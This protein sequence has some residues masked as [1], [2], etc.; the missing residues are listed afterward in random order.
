[1]QRNRNKHQLFFL[2]FTALLQGCAPSEE[3]L[4]GLGSVVFLVFLFMVILN[5]VVPA[6][7]EF[8]IIRQWLPYIERMIDKGFIFLVIISFILIFWGVFSILTNSERSSSDLI[9]FIG[10]LFFYLTIN[11]K[12]W[13]IEKDPTKKKNY[14]RLVGL[15]L[16]FISLI[17]YLMIGAPNLKL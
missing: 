10:I 2:F 16:S 17:I 5:F 3:E 6:I 13:A 8:K 4:W 7:Q 15:A 9:F 14:M 12:K 11:I 1:M